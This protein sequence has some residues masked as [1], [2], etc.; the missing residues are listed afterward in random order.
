MADR[1]K[2]LVQ[3]VSSLLPT[4]HSA[5]PENTMA[6]TNNEQQAFEDEVKQLQQ[7]W[8]DSR[9]RYTRRPFTAEQ[10]AS[11]RGTIK[12]EYPSNAM[13]KKLW[14]TVEGRFAVR[15]IDL[16]TIA[17][18]KEL[19]GNAERRRQ[20]HLRLPRPRDGHANGQVP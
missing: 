1:V 14:K 7:W 15:S 5:S 13:A 6:D 18:T 16:F 3:S 8:S 2:Q 12:I 9:W 19:M 10:I 4:S 17:R 20:L 11:K